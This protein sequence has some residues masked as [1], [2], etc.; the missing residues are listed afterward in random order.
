[1][2]VE[3][4]FETTYLLV[5][6]LDRMLPTLADSRNHRETEHKSFL[7]RRGGVSVEK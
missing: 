2:N 4:C 3:K 1:M 5:K 6:P 7:L